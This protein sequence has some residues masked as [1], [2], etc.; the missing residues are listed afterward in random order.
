VLQR[1]MA[2]LAG[3]WA[4]L[5]LTIGAVAAPSAFA[6]LERAQAGRYAARV[7]VIEAYASLALAVVLI[8]LSRRQASTT[9]GEGVGSR[10]SPELGLALG[11]LFCTVA[12]YFA[13]QPMMDAARAGQGA[14]SF[15][16]LHGISLGFF[17]LKGVLLLV[18]AWRA[19]AP[20]PR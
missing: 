13:V 2:W 1:W 14:L 3:L 12:G 15:A 6:V 7:F 8:L 9:A 11:A 18:L 19:S 16:A 10:F 17:G 20:A 5:V 4:G